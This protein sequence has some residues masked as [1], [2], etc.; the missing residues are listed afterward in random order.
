MGLSR[1]GMDSVYRRW[2]EVGL[3]KVRDLYLEEGFAS[4]EELR[5]RIKLPLGIVADGTSFRSKVNQLNTLSNSLRK[6]LN[7]K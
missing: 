6:K 4:L 5:E 7:S 3:V 2:R 1:G